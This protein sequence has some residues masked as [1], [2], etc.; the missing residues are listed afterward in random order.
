MKKIIRLTESELRD[1]ISESVKR[2]LSEDVLGDNW[3]EDNNEDVYN[4]Y[5]PFEDQEERDKEE[6]D[7]WDNVHDW[8][9]QGEEPIDPSVYDEDP[10]MYKSVDYPYEPSDN[11][12]YHFGEW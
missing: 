6:E 3:H 2:L 8:G 10:D 9:A 5:E 4:N 7:Y 12:L 11:E 1:I